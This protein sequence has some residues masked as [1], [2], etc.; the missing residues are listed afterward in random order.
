MTTDFDVLQ[1]RATNT[2]LPADERVAALRDLAR[3]NPMLAWDALVAAAT[4]RNESDVLSRAAGEEVAKIVFPDQDWDRAP[5]HDFTAEAY[6]SF[7]AEIAR[8]GSS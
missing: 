3:V 5:L 8:L 6:L 4:S 1:S 7:D 2:A